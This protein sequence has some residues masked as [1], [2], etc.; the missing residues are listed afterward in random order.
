MDGRLPL[1]ALLSSTLVAFTIE[2]DNESEHL[3]PHRTTNHGPSADSLHAPWLVSMAMWTNCMQFIC[4]GGVT[5][6]E[7]YRLAR[8]ETNLNGMERWGYIVVRPNPADRRPKPPR[9]DWLIRATPNGRRAQEVWRPLFGV[10]E[11]RWEERFGIGHIDRLRESLRGLTSQLDAELPDCLPILG[12]GLF[13]KGPDLKRCSPAREDDSA[14]SLSLPALLSKTLLAFAIEFERDSEV[15]LAIS[16]NVLRVVGA[17][18]VRVRDLP[19]LAGVSKEA[20]ATAL[21][22]LGKQGYAVIAAESPGSRAKSVRLTPK[23]RAAQDQYHRLVW[24]IEERW[25][26]RFGREAICTLR[27]LLE[28]LAGDGTST[29]SPLFRGLEP[30]ADGWRASVPRPVALPHYPMILHRGGFPDGS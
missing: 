9:P 29:S 1:P 18:G 28:R 5:V 7:L 20:I 12:Y 26:K 13:S 22:F 24:A 17:D 10:M 25:Q 2:F 11:K 15:S 23:G 21:S 6:R 8:T 30:Y 19:G 27:E 16:A 4:E 3:M 14:S